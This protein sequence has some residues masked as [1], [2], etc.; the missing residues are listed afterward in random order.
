MGPT[1]H[2]ATRPSL[3]SSVLNECAVDPWISISSKQ[4]SDPFKAHFC[5]PEF[6]DCVTDNGQKSLLRNKIPLFEGKRVRNLL[7]RRI[8]PF[9]DN[10]SRH[11]RFSGWAES[12]Q[13]HPGLCPPMESQV[14]LVHPGLSQVPIP[15]SPLPG[16]TVGVTDKFPLEFAPLDSANWPRITL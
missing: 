13:S 14:H 12:T 8:C 2:R 16:H 9:C 7:I 10:E 11:L 6:T 5:S 15:S 3:Y 1:V 4:Q